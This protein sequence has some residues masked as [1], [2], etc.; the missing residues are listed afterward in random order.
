M[1][2]TVRVDTSN[3]AGEF[4]AREQLSQLEQKLKDADGELLDVRRVLAQVDSEI[5][6]QQEEVKRLSK[7]VGETE[8]DRHH[9]TQQIG[10]H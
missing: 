9:L 4:G 10:L 1:G 6:R 7:F 5:N 2:Q 3:P 8:Q